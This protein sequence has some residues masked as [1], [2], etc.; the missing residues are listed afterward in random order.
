MTTK[1]TYDLPLNRVEGDLEVRLAVD[2]GVVVDAWSAGTMYRGFE[3]LLLGRGALDGLV[4]TPRICGICSTTHLLAA[5]K[6]LDMIADVTPPPNGVRL[7]NAALMAELVQSD[8]RHTILFFLVD[9]ASPAYR[10]HPLYEEAVRRFEPV[11]GETWV[12]TIIETKK[13]MEITALIAG[14]WPHSSFMV[15]GG[16]AFVPHSTELLQ[17]RYI[18][19]RLRAWYEKRVLGCSFER[20]HAVT[21]AADLD[22]WLDESPA[23]HD[24]VLGFFIRFARSSGLD[25]TGRG[26]DAFLSFGSLD[27]PPGTGV[28]A[29]DGGP[30]L[31]PAGFSQGGVREPFS[32]G[33]VREDV[34]HS[35]AADYEGGLHPAAGITEPVTGE[36]G[37]RYSWAKAPRYDGA[38]AET[39]PLAEAIVAGDP[40][41]TDLA[42]T[43]GVGTFARQ[44]ARL[45]RPARLLPAMEA[46]ISEVAASCDEPGYQSYSPI[47]EGSGHGLIQAARGALGHWV[48]VR[49]GRIA[50]YQVITPTAWNGSP[51]DSAGLR[52]PWEEA[53]VGTVIAEKDDPVEAGHVVRSFDACLVCAV[54]AVDLRADSRH[55]APPAS[56]V[57]RFL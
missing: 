51:R 39:G 5:A 22:A 46:W 17:S 2:E 40:L 57:R 55:A 52:G 4:V 33:L 35:L 26:H 15:P 44:L 3:R 37:R 24:G 56:P 18:L 25:A 11:R 50:A 8:L 29:P 30:H 10:H 28:R 34:S 43:E 38:P 13:I 21:S 7:R 14:Q 41:F 6:A 32:P 12:E 16:V 9:L 31:I 19:A 54:H 23:H 47:E 53:L 42:D 49:A 48:D 45:T 20:W 36:R 27:L 1:R